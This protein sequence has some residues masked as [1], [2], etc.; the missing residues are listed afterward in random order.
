MLIMGLLLMF[1]G[2]FAGLAR[3]YMQWEWKTKWIIIIG[4]SHKYFGFAVL[5]GSQ[6]AIYTGLMNFYKVQKDKDSTGQVLAIIQTAF[7]FVMLIAGE[8]VY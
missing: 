6:V 2:I 7:F 1:G 4:A 8:V 5:I 3:R